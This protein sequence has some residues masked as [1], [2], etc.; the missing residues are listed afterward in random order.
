LVHV[1]TVRR[2]IDH[3]GT[4]LVLSLH[5][6]IIIYMCA[7]MEN[8]SI[9]CSL[10]LYPMM[11]RPSTIL[12]S[13]FYAL[14]V[15]I[16]RVHK[17]VFMLATSRSKYSISAPKENRNHNQEQKSLKNYFRSWK[18]LVLESYHRKLVLHRRFRTIQSAIELKRQREWK[19][20]IRATVHSNYNLYLKIWN[21]WLLYV[22][23]SRDK[24][25]KLDLATDHGTSD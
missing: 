15:R 4:Q 23:N 14:H 18:C 9:A 6:C 5:F 20:H 11:S 1:K 12:P 24:K 19:N 7:A 25:T 22:R 21:G 16:S 2:G 10:N 3:L 13:F 8:L 17:S